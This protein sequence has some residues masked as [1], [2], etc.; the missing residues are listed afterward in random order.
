MTT[1]TFDPKNPPKLCPECAKKGE[2]KKVKCYLINLDSEGVIMCEDE[3][4]PW[5]FDSNLG[6]RIVV[7]QVKQGEKESKKGKLNKSVS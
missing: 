5:P 7:E 1:E 6:D 4:C 2:R 3:K